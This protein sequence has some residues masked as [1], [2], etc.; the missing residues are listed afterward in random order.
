[1]TTTTQTLP[2]T[3]TWNLDTAH[4]NVE[5]IAR[6]LM[7]TK[8]R[9]GFTALEGTVEIAEPVTD[10]SIDVTIQAAS[11]TSGDDKRDGHLKSEDFLDVEKFPTLRFVSTSITAKGDDYALVG[12]LTIKDVAVP[13]TL[14][15]SF[16]GVA[17]DPWGAAHA[18][19]EATGEFNRDDFGII[20]NQTLEAGG[21]LIS[22]TIKLQLDV[23]LVQ[24]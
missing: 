22:K 10:S 21:V 18:A 2:V 1:M 24:S 23:Q 6:H 9:V 12:D 17:T 8:V 11:I 7:V 5:A 16:A 14:E 19:F 20:W 3:G 4:T 13:V 15:L